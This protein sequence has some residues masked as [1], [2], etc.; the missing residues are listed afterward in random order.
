MPAFT[1]TALD[2]SGKP[3]NGTL[4]ATD[5]R[6]AA[7]L[8]AAQN[9]R[10]L[11]LA[12]N[13]TAPEK[14]SERNDAATATPPASPDTPAPRKLSRKRLFGVHTTAN[15]FVDSFYQL[16]TSGL[17]MGDAVKLLSLRVSDPALRY[18]C[19]SLWRD[20]SEG[21]TLAG[22]MSR[23]PK[24][25]DNATLHLIE[26][27]ESTGNLAP[28]LKK[29]LESYALR[30]ALRSKILSSIGYPTALCLMTIGVLAF[31]VFGLIPR[32]EKIMTSLGGKFPWTVKALMA[33]SDFLVKGGPF[34]LV[35]I[36]LALF[37]FSRW[38]RTESGRLISDRLFLRIPFAGP[39]FL[40]TETVRI[41]DLLSTLLGSGI[42]AT[43]ALRLCERP[44]ENRLLRERLSAGRQMINDGAAFASAF[45]YH[46]ILPPSDIDIL[47]VG[48]NTGSLADTFHTIAL[49]HIN[50][51]DKAIRRLSRI[52]IIAVF[53]GTTSLIFICVVSVILTI[54]SVGQNI[55]RH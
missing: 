37:A 7:R 38:R 34:I 6:T 39:V 50:A 51:L 10:P 48:E 27:G 30:E 40:H 3:C 24:V 22:A 33:F 11:S 21:A 46:S 45:K 26:A 4:N 8:L 16:H 36:I 5:R 35:F 23:F 2:S 25:F 52:I 31:F 28:V 14:R 12:S 53:S 55:T 41:T 44:V 54:L 20:I 1:Y 18:L 9:L 32:L 17:P 47:A 42:N 19:Q 13:G 15:D 49:R 29:T 43:D